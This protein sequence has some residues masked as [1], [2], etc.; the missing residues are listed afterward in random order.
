MCSRFLSGNALLEQEG[1]AHKKSD[2]IDPTQE[3]AWQTRVEA[4]PQSDLKSRV[5]S[6]FDIALVFLSAFRSFAYIRIT[7]EL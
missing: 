3:E 7:K 2:W 6:K 5:C 4:V 1:N